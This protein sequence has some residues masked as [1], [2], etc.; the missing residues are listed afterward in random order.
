MDIDATGK[1]RRLDILEGYIIRLWSLWMIHWYWEHL[2]MVVR[3][4]RY[5]IASFKVYHG[6]IHVE[7]L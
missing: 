2:A 7:S 4:S 6:V 5:Y 3:V 1:E